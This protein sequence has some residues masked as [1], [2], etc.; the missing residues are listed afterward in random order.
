MHK[1]LLL[2]LCS[3]R[4]VTNNFQSVLKSSL[5]KSEDTDCPSNRR[6]FQAPSH[7]CAH[8]IWAHHHLSTVGENALYWGRGSW[9]AENVLQ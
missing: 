6:V 1:I 5:T 7:S 2:S 3:N 9:G 4:P 8:D